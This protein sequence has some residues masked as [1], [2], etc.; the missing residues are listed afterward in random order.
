MS[1][2]RTRSPLVGVAIVIA[3]MIGVTTLAA[4]AVSGAE[5]S[6]GSVTIAVTTEPSTLD[7][8]LVNDRNSRVVTANLYEALLGRDATGEIVPRLAESYENTSETT[9]TF[10]LR[11]DVT[12][13]DGSTF[14]ADDVVFSVERMISEDFDT[15]RTSYTDAIV[16]A[17]AVD[18]DTVEIETDG[19]LA[20][21]P[22]QLTQIPI[23]SPEAAETLDTN[24]VGTG[25]Y[26]F[27]EWSTGVSVT[28]ERYDDYWGDAPLVDEFTVR[29]IGD[30]QTALSALQAGEIDLV[31]DILPEQRDQAPVAASV[32]ASEFSYIA[33]NTYLP[34][35]SDPRVRVAFNMAIDKELLAET[36][37]LGEAAPNHAQHLSEGMLG[38]N[39]DLGPI[40]YDPEGAQALLEEA[41]YP[42]DE[43]IELN[44]PIGRYLKGEESAEF[45]AAQL[46]EIGVN[47]EIVATEFNTYREV[48]RIPGTEEGA[49]DL[50]YGW[51]SN[52]FFDGG[53]ILS[54]I[55]CEGPSSKICIPEV[56][57]LM[58]LG[59]SSLDPE[60]RE[61]AYQDVWAILHE[62]PHAIYLLQQNLLYGLS[63]RLEWEPR[64]DDEYYVATMSVNE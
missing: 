2:P 15:Q 3:A 40:A 5:P 33:F 47:V 1:T 64:L 53:R 42:F 13:H 34:A 62:D 9:W 49:M 44:V 48:G 36:V 19:V 17:T 51:N 29:F 43:V 39:P 28:A 32:P 38:Y 54:H 50:K 23:V 7:A 55:T 58:E 41:G 26:Q 56:D 8:Q 37:Y 57:E 18:A 12:F 10:E 46:G 63:E 25:P 24:P 52:E 14:D 6:G 22:A 30:N 60:V 61:Q 59:A 45:V 35:L 20:T 21:L 11:D 16:G 27:V 4:P 31:I